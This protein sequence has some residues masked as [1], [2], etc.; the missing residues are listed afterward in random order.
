MQTSTQ[1]LLGR[2][3]ARKAA[4][5]VP[6]PDTSV[7]ESFEDLLSKYKQIQLE[8]ECIRKEETMALE[9]KALPAREDAP[10]DDASIT[11]TRPVPE[12]GQS[13]AGAEETAE[14]EK[15]ERKVFQAFNIKPL[16]QK[17]PTPANLDELQ[18]KWAEQEAGGGADGEE[19]LM[20]ICRQMFCSPDQQVQVQ[21]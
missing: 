2:A 4:H 12:P 6:K 8:L 7:D 9:P 10:D 19:T 17:L 15:A 21:L 13:P 20:N 11:E 3:Q 16:R 1:K 5:S 18:R 14:L